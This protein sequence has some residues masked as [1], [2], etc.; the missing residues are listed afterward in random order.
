MTK[1]TKQSV[2][3]L[4]LAL[5][6]SY[7]YCEPFSYGV[8]PNAASTGMNWSMGSVLP[9]VPGLDI[10][11]LIYRYTTNKITEDDMRVTIGNSNADG[12][13]Y[14][15]RETDDWSGLPGNTIT[16]KFL[17]NNIPSAQWGD[18]SIEVEGEGTVEDPLVAYSYRVDFCADPQTDPSCPGYIRPTPQITDVD[19]YNALEDEAVV[20]ALDQDPNFKYDEDGNLILDKPE[21]EEETRLELGLMAAEN[22]ITMLKSQ[23]QSELINQI[24]MQ[25]DINMYYNAR[26]GG[27]AYGDGISDNKKALRN[28]LAQQLLHEQMVQSQYGD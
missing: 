4:L 14:T 27:G 26:I 5:L 7:S 20:A 1:I 24:N 23:G 21:K 19:V 25:T 13:G 16:K 22:A 28:N 8:T 15:F 18:G 2:S 3:A 17:F 9:S 11:G 12:S 10:N 6:P